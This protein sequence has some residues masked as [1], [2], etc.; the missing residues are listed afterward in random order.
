MDGAPFG[1]HI[2]NITPK[3]H[4]NK[5][6]RKIT[7]FDVMKTVEGNIAV[8]VGSETMVYHAC[9]PTPICKWDEE[10]RKASGFDAQRK[11]SPVSPLHKTPY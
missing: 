3:D 6:E 8:A 10:N 1:Y 5:K 2:F 9:F 7:T 4:F 11:M